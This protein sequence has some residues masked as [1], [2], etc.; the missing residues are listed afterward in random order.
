MGKDI[1][2]RVRNDSQAEYNAC[3]IKEL[4]ALHSGNIRSISLSDNQEYLLSTDGKTLLRWNIERS[5]QPH[6]LFTAP[7]ISPPPGR[8]SEM[9]VEMTD[10][11]QQY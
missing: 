2:P 7:L 1:V 4:P 6:L 8:P 10:D 5:I 11:Q 3:E 9:E